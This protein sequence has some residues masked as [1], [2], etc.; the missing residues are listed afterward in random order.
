M[1]PKQWRFVHDQ[2]STVGFVAIGS[3][4]SLRCGASELHS[5][6]Q[7]RRRL[8]EFTDHPVEGLCSVTDFGVAIEGWVAGNSANLWLTMLPEVLLAT[9]QWLTLFGK[10]TGEATP[11]S[12]DAVLA[13]LS[14]LRQS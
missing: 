12:V 13:G 3:G 1:G 14:A 5:L 6:N 7:L 2:G 11:N 10:A 4:R 9:R 8:K